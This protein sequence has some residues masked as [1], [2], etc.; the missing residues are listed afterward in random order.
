MGKISEIRQ[1]GIETKLSIPKCLDIDDVLTD[2]MGWCLILGKRFT[3]SETRERIVALYKIE[4]GNNCW[5][6]FDIKQKK[7]TL[8]KKNGSHETT[9]KV[10]HWSL[11]NIFK[12][13]S[14]SED[15]NQAMITAQSERTMGIRIPMIKRKI[16]FILS[17]ENGRSY[18]VCCDECS[19]GEETLKQVEVE[20]MNHDIQMEQP[21]LDVIA[22]DIKQIKDLIMEIIPELIPTNQS[23]SEFIRNNGSRF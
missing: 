13:E 11:E 14:E 19:I 7:L 1:I 20:S 8:K 15:L 12:Y 5:V 10:A 22:E 4:G 18:E 21:M 2:I 6:E 3:V 16:A 23:K 9:N 17:L